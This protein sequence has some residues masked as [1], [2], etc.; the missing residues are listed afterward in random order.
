MLTP[1]TVDYLRRQTYDP[2]AEQLSIIVPVST[3]YWSDEMPDTKAL[4]RLGNGAYDEVIRL[5]SIRRQIWEHLQVSNEEQEFWSSAI[6]LAPDFPGF[7][8]L[9][10]SPEDREAQFQIDRLE[11]EFFDEL[12]ESADDF[13]I[14]VAG[15]WSATFHLEEKP[16]KSFWKRLIPG[17][18]RRLN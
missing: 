8:R 12:A 4:R 17:W 1:E 9:D 11:A 10:L 2:A 5:L 16:G 7:R 14:D 13:E 6:S 18:F 3:L 15:N